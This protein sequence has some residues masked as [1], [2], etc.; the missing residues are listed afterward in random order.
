MSP[1]AD[2]ALVVR[3]ALRRQDRAGRGWGPRVEFGPETRPRCIVPGRLRATG[4]SSPRT[5][6]PAPTH[7]DRRPCGSRTT[8]WARID[9]RSCSTRRW[10]DLAPAKVVEVMIARVSGSR[11]W[12][13]RRQGSGREVAPGQVSAGERQ[14]ACERQVARAGG[15]DRG[16][17]CGGGW[18]RGC[19][20]SGRR[21]R[22]RHTEVGLRYGGGERRRWLT[23][24]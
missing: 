16:R 24:S 15:G 8:S 6:R 18:R 5:R 22:C 20:R 19:D 3:Q 1:A 9:C 13:R 14:V 10:S 23:G 17:R 12:S 11:R 7:W 2:R 21:L 4:A